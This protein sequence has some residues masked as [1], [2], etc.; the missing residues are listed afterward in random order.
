MD[1]Q[2]GDKHP[3]PCDRPSLRQV[4]GRGGWLAGRGGCVAERAL[5]AMRGLAAVADGIARSGLAVVGV[6]ASSGLYPATHLT[7]SLPLRGLSDVSRLMM[8]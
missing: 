6:A 4:G 7:V 5:E 2:R 8:M 1:P 3:L